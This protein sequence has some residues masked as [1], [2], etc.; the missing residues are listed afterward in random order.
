MSAPLRLGSIHAGVQGFFSEPQPGHYTTQPTHYRKKQSDEGSEY[1]FVGAKDGSEMEKRKFER[2][3][4]KGAVVVR[5][6]DKVDFFV[7][8]RIKVVERAK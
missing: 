8:H 4:T 2:K 5:I 1:S 6:G 7:G 3:E